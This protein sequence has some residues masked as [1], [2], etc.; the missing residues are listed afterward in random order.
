[1]SCVCA[2]SS[3]HPCD[4]LEENLVSCFCS[5]YGSI[6]PTPS[7]LH[8][9]QLHGNQNVCLTI[10][11]SVPCSGNTYHDI[12][13]SMPQSPKLHQSTVCLSTYTGSNMKAQHYRVQPDYSHTL[14]HADSLQ[15]ILSSV[16]EE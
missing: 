14:L 16:L 12:V 10:D 1:M 15:V 7:V 5:F 6:H 8:L 13:E 2:F 3:L 4:F 11:R 9:L